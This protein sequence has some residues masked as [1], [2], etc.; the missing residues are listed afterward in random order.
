[1]GTV[2]D[3]RA[4]DPSYHSGL[5]FS[6]FEGLKQGSKFR[7][8]SGENPEFLKIQFAEAKISNADFEISKNDG[9][10]WDVDISKLELQPKDRH[11]EGCCGICGGNKK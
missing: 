6:F 2:I 9:A 3:L 10:T 4:L 8:I 5:I 1:M 11:E 7:L